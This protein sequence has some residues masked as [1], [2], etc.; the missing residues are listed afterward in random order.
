MENSTMIQGI[1]FRNMAENFGTPAYIY[2]ADSI[3][4]QLNSFNRAFQGIDFKVKY[5]MKANSNISII[6]LMQKLGTGLDTVSIPEILTGLRVG[7]DPTEIVFTPNMVDFSEIEEAVE[8]GVSINIENLSNLKKFGEKYENRVSCFIRL[9]PFF[10]DQS[11]N[12]DV[13]TWHKQS[14]FGISLNQ[15]G[16]VFALRDQYNMR[17]EGIHL[18]SS[19]VIMS[20]EI[21]IKGLNIILELVKK[22]PEAMIIDLGGGLRPEN[23]IDSKAFDIFELGMELKKSLDNFEKETQKHLSIW[24]EPGRYLISE[25]GYLLV[26]AEILKSNGIHEFVGVNSGFNHLIRPMFY[27]AYHEIVNISNPRGKKKR[28][29]VVGNLCEIDNFAIDR[30][31][32]EVRE[33]DLLLFKHAGA[34]GFSMS[35]HYN[36]RFK[37]VE[38]LVYKGKAHLIRKKESLNDLLLN[39]IETDL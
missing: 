39:Q 35:S 9:N 20:K 26:T 34:Y 18:H 19:H 30:D 22:I 38:V 13:A 14:K 2:D 29:T 28:Y 32:S 21:F 24:F 17:I 27:H 37:P 6:K 5:A 36:S 3:A 7:Y 23:L 10:I 15:M 1:S 16:E 25:A 4:K 33:K 31:L 11:E 12:S 8:L